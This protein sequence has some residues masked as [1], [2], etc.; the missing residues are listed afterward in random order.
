MGQFHSVPAVAGRAVA[1]GDSQPDR[2]AEPRR[3]MRP[4]EGQRSPWAD[5]APQDSAESPD[6]TAPFLAAVLARVAANLCGPG[7]DG[8]QA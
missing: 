1:R 4:P 6:I 3:A 8:P 5:P 2:Q 7:R